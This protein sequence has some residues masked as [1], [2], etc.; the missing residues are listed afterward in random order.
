[1]KKIILILFVFIYFKS[2][3]QIKEVRDFFYV[4]NSPLTSNNFCHGDNCYIDVYGSGDTLAR[5][6]NS[7]MVYWKAQL[8]AA[9]IVDTLSGTGIT[10]LC[11]ITVPNT[12]GTQRVIQYN[13]LA[14]I[15]STNTYSVSFCSDYKFPAT[16]TRL[17]DNQIMCV[18]DT[19]FNINWKVQPQ[20]AWLGRVGTTRLKRIMLP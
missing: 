8:T 16:I 9:N 6:Y 15:F 10:G 7:G 20:W 14:I 19:G 18:I 11:K 17:S 4:Y 1:M 2:T 13:D 3:A 12:T 5:I